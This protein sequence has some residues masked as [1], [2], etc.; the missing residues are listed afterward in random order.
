MPW[1]N[2]YR[3]AQLLGGTKRFVLSTSGHI[4]ALVNP[5]S[6]ESRAS[7]R[8]TDDPAD[9]AE[10]WVAQA[11]VKRGSWWPDYRDWLGERAGELRRRRRRSEAASTRRPRRPRDYVHAS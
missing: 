3:S 10:A 8:V 11:D 4:Q 2:A 1:E 6:P 7:Y 5:P 9:E